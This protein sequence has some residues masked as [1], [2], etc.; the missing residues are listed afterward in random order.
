MCT[1]EK[2]FKKQYGEVSLINPV[3]CNVYIACQYRRTT[4]LNECFLKYGNGQIDF[5]KSVVVILRIHFL[6]KEL[7][8]CFHF[9]VACLKSFVKK[10]HALLL[11][12]CSH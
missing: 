12:I 9:I 8:M 3:Q 6:I 1:H 10:S 5:K 11:L 2:G 7:T 4:G